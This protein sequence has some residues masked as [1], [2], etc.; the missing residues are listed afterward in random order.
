MSRDEFFS[1]FGVEAFRLRKI[2]VIAPVVNKEILNGLKIKKLI[3]GTLF[4]V[5][6]N[7]I[8]SLIATKM[9]SLFVGDAV[10]NL[11]KT[12]CEDIIL[13]G[14]CGAVPD[15]G[16][17]TGTIAISEK[18][19]SQ[20]SFVNMLL[21]KKCD[22][23]YYPDKNL[24]KIFLNFKDEY[25]IKCVTS[26]SVGSLK[27]EE[28][29]LDNLDA[30][31]NSSID[32]VDMETSALYLASQYIKKRALSFLIVT[33]IL[34]QYPYYR[35]MEKENQIIFRQMAAKTSKIL[36]KLINEMTRLNNKRIATEF[37]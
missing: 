15:K 7:G 21:Q 4:S 33:D 30:I 35:A 25:N 13:F 12:K 1:L 36:F 18:A 14:S 17:G 27:L 23:I 32:I 5:G 19:F 3:K 28:K 29:Y 24:L 9:G 37:Y 22:T 11:E 31:Q 34:K 8:F 20:D 2:C 26:I 6:D 10:L 16:L